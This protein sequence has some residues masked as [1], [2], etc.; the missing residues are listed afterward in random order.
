MFPSDNAKI[1][2]AAEMLVKSVF[3]D[4]TDQEYLAGQGVKRSFNI[5]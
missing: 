1:F 4:A 2:K 5:N 3:R